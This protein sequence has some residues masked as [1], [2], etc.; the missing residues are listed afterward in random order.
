V[1][2]FNAAQD[3]ADAAIK[4][5]LAAKLASQLAAT[6]ATKDFRGSHP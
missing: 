1:A 2:P 6:H 5:A 4:T 3:S